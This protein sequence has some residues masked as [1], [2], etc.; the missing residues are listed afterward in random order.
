MHKLIPLLALA[1]AAPA[2]A[3]SSAMW[4]VNAEGRACTASQPGATAESGRLS[5]TYDAA[6]PEVTLT[7]IN[8][9]ES[10]L[11]ARGV[12]NLALVFVDNGNEPYDEGWGF[13][14]VA[15]A[16]RGD[17]VE[18]STRFTGERNVKQVLADLAHSRRVGFVQHGEPVIAY[19]LDGIGPALDA[20]RSCAARAAG[21]AA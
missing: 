5:I 11:P 16:R 21:G 4:P 7:S 12:V 18:F 2:L 8:Q 13:R 9:V 3:Q 10:P 19:I 17:A 6:A 15:F 14:R 1:T 20:L